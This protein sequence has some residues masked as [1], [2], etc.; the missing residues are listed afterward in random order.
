MLILSSMIISNVPQLW[1]ETATSRQPSCMN[2]A[3]ACEAASM[4]QTR[5][6]I[7]R[8]CVKPVV[9]GKKAYRRLNISPEDI[10]SCRDRI[11]EHKPFQWRKGANQ[12]IGT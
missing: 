2:L 11:Q 6:Q 7:W 3:V 10:Q 4:G 1:A 12:H 8:N 9:E 5:H